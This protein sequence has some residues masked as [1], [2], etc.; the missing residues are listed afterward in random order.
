MS[1]GPTGRNRSGTNPMGPNAQAFFRR[2]LEPTR[3]DRIAD[4]AA[5]QQAI[6]ECLGRQG[7][8]YRP[9]PQ[10]G[11]DMPIEDIVSPATR[12]RFGYGVRRSYEQSG[13]VSK[14]P[15]SDYLHSLSG[16]ARQAY[17]AALVDCS[18]AATRST[19]LPAAL[20]E[21]IDAAEFNR[22]LR[23]LAE[24]FW[25]RAEI[26]KLLDRYRT[27][28]HAKGF[29]VTGYSDPA[30]LL[31]HD[32]DRLWRDASYRDQVF[33]DEVRVSALDAACMDTVYRPLRR[34]W[35]AHARESLAD[36]AAMLDERGQ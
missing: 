8:Q 11:L 19:S 29:Q 4:W 20:L 10:Q 30:E 28:M 18:M 35:L 32:L 23:D 33:D 5:L 6:A 2:L 24:Q 26:V 1:R 25:A 7:L 36:I 13:A 27:C 21:R 16:P 9:V 12:R 31:P 14:D 17:R 34:G 22:R 15:N 3:Q